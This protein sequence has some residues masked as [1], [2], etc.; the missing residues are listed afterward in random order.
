MK[1]RQTT[2]FISHR[3][4]IGIPKD[5]LNKCKKVKEEKNNLNINSAFLNVSGRIE[6]LRILQ[7]LCCNH[8]L[9]FEVS[10]RFC[11]NYNDCLGYMNFQF[12]KHWSSRNH[13]SS[14]RPSNFRSLQCNLNVWRSEK[15][16]F[17]SSK[18]LMSYRRNRKWGWPFSKGP[19][20]FRI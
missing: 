7:S 2:W 12:I 20:K 4:Q 15:V 17:N 14:W 5:G 19:T 13:K 16:L 11:T 3:Q 8:S 1:H 6:C 9:H 10:H 18:I